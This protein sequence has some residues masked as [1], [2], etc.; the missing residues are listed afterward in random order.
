MGRV[1]P[2]TRRHAA[3]L[4]IFAATFLTMIYGVIP[5]DE[6][7]LPLPVLGWWFPELSGLFLVS[8]IIVAVAISMPAIQ[9]KIAFEKRRNAA[10]QARKER[11]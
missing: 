5:F 8:A 11:V 7:G 3:I 2:L 1:Q 9:E 10:R 6:M 4:L